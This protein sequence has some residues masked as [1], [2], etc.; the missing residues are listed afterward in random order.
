ML[1][2]QCCHVSASSLHQV[3]HRSVSGRV[4]SGNIASNALLEKSPVSLREDIKGVDRLHF[5]VLVLLD[6]QLN[7]FTE[8]ELGDLHLVK[9]QGTCLVGANVG[10]TSHD[11]TGGELFHVI[12]ILEHFALGV[13]ERNHD[14]EGQTFGDSDDDNGD[15][16]NDVINP[17]LEVL[18]EVAAIIVLTSE[19][20]NVAL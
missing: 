9:S 18:G 16:D 20:I 5:L 19:K 13:G 12:L 17:E 2:G 15:T 1:L 14:G 3:S 6:V 11:L 8:P 10:G 7:V 4:I